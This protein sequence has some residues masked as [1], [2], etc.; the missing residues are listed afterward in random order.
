MKKSVSVV[1]FVLVFGECCAFSDSG[2]NFSQDEKYFENDYQKTSAQ[3]D[4]YQPL[5][6]TKIYLP[7]SK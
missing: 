5:T 2:L 7:K 3:S 6:P 4:Y 1:A